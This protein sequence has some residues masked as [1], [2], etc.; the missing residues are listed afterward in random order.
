MPRAPK[1]IPRKKSKK[2]FKR[3]S[4][5]NPRNRQRRTPMRGGIRF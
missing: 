1:R 4:S 3:T 2:I 5:M